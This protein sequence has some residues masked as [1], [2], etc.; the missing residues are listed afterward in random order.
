MENPT[1][2]TE[3]QKLTFPKP[4]RVDKDGFTFDGITLP[5]ELEHVLFSDL[6][7]YYSPNHADV[8]FNLDSDS[9]KIKN[10]LG[11]YFPRSFAESYSIY[12]DVLC[13]QPVNSPGGKSLI[14]TDTSVSILS[15]GCGTG[16]D[17]VGGIYALLENRPNLKTI[18][19]TGI[20]GNELALEKAEYI[21]DCIRQASKAKILFHPIRFNA[22]KDD[23]DLIKNQLKPGN[24]DFVQTFKTVGELPQEPESP[25]RYDSVYGDVTS[26]FIRYIKPTGLFIVLD[27]CYPDE[28]DKIFYPIYLNRQ[29]TNFL[30]HNTEYSSLL[31]VPCAKVGICRFR[32]FTEKYF[33]IQHRQLGWGNADLSKVAFRVLGHSNFVKRILPQIPEG[34]YSMNFDNPRDRCP[35]IRGIF[36]EG[37]VPDAFTLESINLLLDE[38]S[39]NKG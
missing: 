36:P 1:K 25:A 17:V 24:F 19:I 33:F 16:G 30:R 12:K 39:K 35:Y 38:N 21:I 15:F 34:H 18:E 6:E 10:Y 22:N 8:R 31:P 23:C 29:I 2:K 7:A 27:L 32:C 20:D 11:T 14:A 28:V 4:I 13:F 9:K 5:T 3:I 37:A 26:F